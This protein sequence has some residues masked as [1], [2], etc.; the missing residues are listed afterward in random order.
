MVMRPYG[1]AAALALC[2]WLGVAQGTAGAS[3]TLGETFT[4]DARC[5]PY[6]MMQTGSPN[7]RYAAPADGVLTAW[8][9]RATDGFSDAEP[10]YTVL[11]M[12]GRPQPGPKP[13]RYTDESV[14][15]AVPLELNTFPTR[16]PVEAGDVIGL[17]THR[18]EGCL[19]RTPR[20]GYAYVYDAVVNGPPHLGALYDGAP[21]RLNVSAVWSRTSITIAMAMRPRTP[22]WWR[23]STRIRRVI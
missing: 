8:S 16:I 21:Y 11:L 22:A 23:R 7:N 2:L 20:L 12:V 19:D 13:V 9:H 5:S 4:S 1:F 14:G 18:S 15:Q 6:P 3:I 17:S 10:S